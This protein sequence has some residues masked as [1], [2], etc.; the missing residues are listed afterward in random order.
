MFSV[1][2]VGSWPRSEK[3]LEALHKYEACAISKDEFTIIT[4][5]AIRRCVNLQHKAG[6]DIV[7]DGEISRSGF[8]PF[9]S[10]KL[11]GVQLMSMEETLDKKDAEKF[12]ESLSSM[13][14]E[15]SGIKNPTCVGKLTKV[16]N[17][18]LEEYLFLKT[19]TDKPIKVTLPG[20]YLLTR[21]MF[22]DKFST[23]AYSDKYEMGKDIV[24]ILRDEVIALRD[25]GCD[26]VQFDEPIL[27]EVVFMDNSSPEQSE[28][29]PDR[30]FM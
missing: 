6:V 22:V 18:A 24:K 27:T 2:Q 25:A 17:L 29:D 30:T 16:E 4:Q 11:N 7:V 13:D 12:Q 20:P 9:I 14:A 5:E 1:T 8:Y 19:L 3:V 28:D 15:T 23:K 10:K 21:T 26:F